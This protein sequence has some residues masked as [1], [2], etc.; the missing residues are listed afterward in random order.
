MQTRCCSPPE[1]CAGKMPGAIF[2]P[3]VRQ[4]VQRFLL[5]GHAVKVL[6]Q[7]DVFERSEVGNQMEL[8]K[9]EANFFRAGAIQILGR[10]LGNVFAVKPDLA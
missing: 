3:N 1:S 5:V 2:Q 4:S 6:R 8:L 10:E 7:H 9:D